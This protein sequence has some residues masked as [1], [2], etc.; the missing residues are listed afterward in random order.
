MNA[1]F[2]SGRQLEIRVN[3]PVAENVVCPGS[4]AGVPS[5]CTARRPKFQR[6]SVRRTAKSLRTEESLG[7]FPPAFGKLRRAE[8]NVTLSG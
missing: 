8:R 6:A 4:F 7:H 5:A 2:F 1:F 3:F